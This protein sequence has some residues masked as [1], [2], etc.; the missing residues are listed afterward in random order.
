MSIRNIL[1][2]LLTTSILLFILVII[3]TKPALA[4]SINVSPDEG[5][6]DSLIYLSG[7][8]FTPDATVRTYFTYDTTYETVDIDIVASDGT[9]SQ[10]F[11]I[12]EVPG[13]SYEV[14][15]ETSYEYA[16]DFF[17][18][19]PNIELSDTSSIVGERI[20]IYGAGFRANRGVTIKFDNELLASTST[21]SR[22]SFSD[23]F[24]VPESERGSH[25]VTAYDR[26][27]RLSTRLSVEQSISITPD[28]GPT[29]TKVT[30]R[31]TGFRD[32][33]SITITFNDDEIDITPSS[34]T[35]DSSGSFTA[36]LNVPI[37][38]NRTPEIVASDG[39][40][41]ASAEFTILASI[42][43]SP[44]SGIPGDT[45]T[46]IGNGFR[47]NRI[48]RFILDG[49]ELITKPLSI[50]SDNTGCFN[51][52]FDVPAST[53]GTHIVRADDGINST[54]ASFT[55]LPSISLH[56]S[57]GPIGVEITVNGGGF[58]GNKVITIRFSD[59][60]V[61]T[62]ATDTSGSFTDHFV[63][64]QNSSGNYE[65]S[66]NDGL[67]TTGTIF[68]I[69]TSIELIP[70]IG[71]VDT[72]VTVIGTGF[73]NAITIQYDDMVVATTTADANGA[74]SI[75]FTAPVSIHG[76]H[77]VVIS[78]S[79]NTIETTFT[80]ESE[81]PPVMALLS[82]ENGARQDSR[83]SFNWE[84]VDDPSGVTYT[85]QIAT[86]DSFSTLLLEK[87]GLTQSNYTLARE[88]GLQSTDSE[89]PYYWRLKAIDG[90]SN[91][92]GW[93]TPWSFFVS[94]IPQW[95]T[96]VLIVAV[97]VFISVL[98]SRKV[99]RKRS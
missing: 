81:V 9:I 33:H 86:D 91:E 41:T 99:W 68:T 90:A 92:S 73:T 89:S 17:T 62:S 87:Q 84:S 23:T 79:I 34:I 69:T 45:V 21:N 57:S 95:A 8:G 37:C 47:T 26:T 22:G 5:E 70:N 20:V 52:D 64:P 1:P 29:G 53:S 25:E 12:P 39:R 31:G 44:N 40:N 54:D 24:S 30:V 67:V 10:F 43:L 19:E 35:T 6:V 14:R 96:Y 93:S 46:V 65:V 2:V 88:E 18:V 75:S 32:D 48:I 77:A 55:T 15:V 74:F 56:P 60:H 28:T 50:R 97:S 63:V 59:D 7:T 98:V 85:L 58:G 78:D 16:S 42:S 82:P 13:G 72:I 80:M 51:V 38:L 61:R 4:S 3:P 27:Y 71:H 11:I 94:F 76:H 83:P 66:A 49:S 36:K